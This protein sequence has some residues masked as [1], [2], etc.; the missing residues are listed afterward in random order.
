LYEPPLTMTA[1]SS[2]AKAEDPRLPF[3]SGQLSSPQS[4]DD[5]EEPIS[6]AHVLSTQN[7]YLMGG[8][9]VQVSC[10]SASVHSDSKGMSE[11]HV[12]TSLPPFV[13]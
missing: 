8:G 6:P 11:I 2:S 1:P 12:S 10:A 5:F 4:L 3:C 7:L 9:L 13:R